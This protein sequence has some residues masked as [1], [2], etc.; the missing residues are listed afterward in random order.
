M[1]GVTYTAT[2][3]KVAGTWSVVVPGSGLIADSDKTI[4]AKVTFTDAAGNSSNITESKTYTVDTTAPSA[5]V[6]DPINATNP[7]T[8]TA[9]AGSTVKV[10]FPDGTTATVVAGPD[11]KWTVPNPGDLKDGDKVTVVATDPAGN[12]S[13]P[14]TGTVDAV[15][16]AVTVTTT[17]TNDSTP[18]LSGTINDPTAKVVV[19]VDGVN[20]SATNNGDGTWTLADNTL[21]VLTDGPHTVTVTATD[22]AGNVGTTNAV[23][24]VD[25]TAPNAPVIDPINATN[26]VTGTAEAGSTVKVTF[27]DGTTATVVAG[28]DGKW[29]V[30]NPGD[31]KDGDKVTVVATDPAGN[32]SAPSTGTVDAVAPA[33]TVTTT[34][35][36]DSTPALS[37]TINDPTAKVVVTVDGVNYPA[38]N[39][40]DGTWTLADNTLPVLTDG[41]HTVTVTA[42]DPAGNVGTTNAV[43]TVDTAAPNAP[44]LDPINATNPVTGTAE[45]GSTV[46]VSFPD[47]TTATVVAGPDGKWTVPN[48]GDL[49]D[50]Q[51]VT[52]TATDPAGNPSLPGTGVVDAVA[53]TV[54]VT[55][56]LT[57]DSTPALTGT[58]NDPTAKVV[59]TVDGVAYPAVNN[60]DGTWTLADNTLP[61]LTD[62]PHTVTVTATDPA[63]NV[64]TGNAV[65]TVDTTAPSAPVLDPINATNPVTGTAE[66]GST[67][68]V[69][70]PDGTTAT[71]VAGPDG[72]WTVLNPGDLTDGQTVTATATDPAGNPSL[73]GTGVVDAVA[74]T[75]AV[76][77]AL[78]NDST[79]ALTGTVNDPTAKVVVTVDGVNYPATN[80]GDGTWTLADNTL[81]VLTDG[82]H[83]VTVT[84]TDPAGN[85]GTGNAVVTVDTTAPSAPILDPINATNPVTGTAEPGST[86]TVSFP[87][88]TTATVV[89]GPDGKWTVPNP[90]DLTDGQTVTAT[91]TD[92]AGNPSLPGT[93][94]VDAVA[95]TVAVTT[96]LTND[97]TPA[98][99]GTVND[100]TAKV[101]VTVDGV[102]YPA[103]NN[104][105]GTWTLADN[106]LPVLT[107]GPHTVTVTATD[108]AGNVG[109][110]NAVVTV[111]TTAPSA[112]VLDPINATNPVTGTAEPGSTV[113]VSFPDGTTATV[114]AGPDGKWTVPN[115]GDLTD[116]QTVTATA[117]DPAGN[118]SL[119]GTGVVDAV[120]PTVA[121]TTALTNDSTPALT[122]TVNDPTAKVVVTVD[123]VAY[124]AVNNGD[125]TWTL[126]DNTLP[127]LTDGPHT[128]TVTATDPAGNVGTGN[129]VVTVDTTAPSAPVLDPI[130]AT[131]PV[132]GTAEPGST[133]TVSFPDGTTATVVAGPDGK[134]TVP[135]PGDLTDGQTV[136]ATATD[137]AGNP[138]LPGTGVVDAVAPTVAV[139]TAL[140]N[141]STP[142]L[143]GTVNDPTAKVVVTVDGVNYP[144]T[145]NGDGTWTLADNTL[146]VLA[147]GPHTVTVTA[148]DPAGNVG[149]TNA[150]V[151]VDTTAPTV[152]LSDVT[153]NDST[154]ELT[155]T[156]NDPSATVVVTVNGVNYTAVNN[157]NGSWTLA[158]NTL[159]VL[160]DGP[161]TVT[162]T[163]TDPAGNV[164][165]TSAVVTVDT[166]AANLLGP[167]TVPDDLNADGFINASELGTDGSF[168]AR[169]ALGPDAA[170]GTVVNVNGTDYTVSATD[171]SNG[172]ITASIPVTA[173]GPI[174]IHAQAVDSQGHISSPTNV[175]VT[176]D[177]AAPGTPVLDPI[178]A[179]NPVTGTAEPGSTV[180]VSFPDGTTATVVAGPDGKWTV[181]N[182]GDLTDGQT[183][184]AT[185]IDPAGN[186]S[187]PGTGVVDAVAPT[188]AVTTTLTNDSTPAL[189]GTVNDPTAKVVVTV[190]GVNYPATNNGDG[191]WTLAD[192]TLPVLTD[193]PHTVTVTA[194]DPAG[195]VG[196]GNAVVT[197]DTTAPSAPVLDPINAT[198]PVTG[199]A[200]PG[201]TVTVSFPDGTTAT[202]VAGPDGKWTVPNPGDLTDGQTVTAT[203][204]DPAGNPS[205]PGT[206]VVDAVAPTVAVTTALTNDS[207]PALTGTVND[208]TAKVVVTVDG[209][210]Y[211]AVNNGDGTWT[212]ADNTLPVLTD[213]PHTVTVTATDPAGNVGTGNAVVTVDT[214]APS[215]PVLD[216]INATNPVTGTAE[217]GSTV[218]VSFP[219]GTTATVVAGPDGKWTVPNP[220]D[221]TDGQT[222]T[223]TATDPA[224]NPSLP[225]TGVVDAVAPTVAV[226]TALTND[227]T[228]AL[229]GTVNDPTAKVVVTVDGVNYPAT[230]NGD[231]TWTLADNT[232]PVLADGPHTVTVTATDP[233]GNVGTTNAVVTVDTTAPTVGLSDVT[234]NDS[235]PEL[236][237]TVNDPSATVVVTVNGVNYTAVNNGNGSWT[238][239]DN[240][241]PVLADGPHT[242]TVTA[243]DPAG[244]VSTTS[245]V[246]T[247]DTAAANLLGP[248]TVPDDLNADGFINASELGTDGSFN[249]R[250]ALG[251]DA[252]VGTVVN[253]NG[254]DYTVSA[255]DLSN[256]YITA[257]IPVTADGPI[258]I[259]AQAVDSQGHISSPADV[260]VTVDTAAPSAPVLDPI[261]AT[262]PVTGTAEPGS[263]V[264]VSFP[265]GTTATVVA[266]PDGKWTVPNPGDLTDGQTVTAIATDPAGNPSLPGTGTVDALAPT[267]AL[268]DVLTND[269]TPALTGTVNDPTAKVVV[270]VDGVNYPATN[271]GDGTWTLADNTLPVLTDGPHTVTVTAT[272]P[273]GNV[274]TG[275]AVVTVDTTA[276]TVGLSDV[277]TNDSTPE[278]T[279]T[280]NDPT[281]TVVVTVNGV[282]YTAVN[283][284]N[285]SWTLADNTLP[286]LADGPHTVTVTATDPAGNVS[287]TSAVVTVDTAAAN[288]L[289]P[290]T[291]PDD[292]NA[293]GFI[294]TSELGTDGSFDARVALG[295]DAAVGT[296]VNV[297]GTDYTVSATDLSNGYIT[298]SI[299]VTADG[300]ITIHAQ[301]VDSQG[302][303]SSPADVIVT[304]DT[305]AP[306]APVL[307]PINAT[308]PVTGTAEP[309]ST[310]T[311]SFPDGT[312]ATVVAGPDGKW[313]VPNPGDLTD[314]QT[315]TAIATD[316]AGNPSLPGTGTVDALAPTVALS[317]VLTN[318]STPAL[319]G[320]VNDPTAKVVVTVDGVDYPATNNGDGTWTLADNTLPVL[321]DGPHTVTVTATDPAGNV[322]TGNAVVT[323]DTTAPTVGLSDVTTNDSTPE[324]TGTVNDPTATVVV[325]VNGVNYTAVNNGNGSWTLADNTLPVLAD[326][327]HT[328]TVTAT[329]PA[330]NVSTTSAV[331]TV[332]TAAANLLGPITVPDDLNADGFINTSE[333][334]TDGS[335]DARVAL[336]PDAAVGTVVNV[337][338][339]D[340]T[341]SATDL[342]NGYITASIPVTADGPITIH[343]QAVDSQGH[344]S[345]PADVIVTVDTAAPSA[346]VL[347]PINATNPVTGTAEPGS[348]VTVS[349]PDGTTATVVAGPDGKWTVPNPGDLTDGQTVTAIATDPAGNPSLPGTGT[350]D[351]LAPT[352]ALSDV[353]TNDSTPA[354]TGTVNDPTAKVVVTVDGVNYPATNN[355]DGT[356]TLADNTLP[357]LTDGPHTVTVTAT[358]PA[359]N[360]G[361]GNAV[362]T[363]DTTAPTVGLSDVTTNDSTPELTGTVN[364]PSA[365]VVVTVNGVNYTAV[366]NGNG[367]WT[368][369][370]NTLPVLADGPHTVTVTATDPAGNVS[371]TS[372]VV[373]VDTA[374]ANLLG[375]ITVP[376]DL[377]A[378]GFINTSELGTDGS[379]DARVA[380]GPDAAVGTVVNVNGT[381]YTVSATDLSNGYITA[382]IPVT[383]DG[384]ITIHAQAVDSQGHISSP[385]DVIVTVDT[386]APS[387][388][389]LDPINATNPVTGT[390]EPGSTVTVSFP[391]GTTATVVAGP[392]GKWTAPNP[393][394]LTD[395]QTVTAIATDPAG[396][397]SL[398]GTGTVDAL[399]PT[400]ALSDVLTN[401]STPALTGTVNDPTAKVVVTVDGVN[402]PATNNGD[403][404][405]TLADNTLPVLTDGPHTV[406]VTAT[407]PA[408]NV[409]TTNAV[410][411]VDTTAPTVGLSDVTTNDSTPELTGTVNDPTATVVVTVNGVNYT[412]VNNGNGSWTLA[413]NTLPVLADGPHT[414][415]VTA[416]D[417]AGNVST[418]SAVV[419][420]DTAAANL[421]GP[422][423][424]PDDLNADGF[425][426]TSELGT[427]GSFDARVALG[428]D[429]AV[430]TVVNV[431]GTDYTVSATDLSNGYITASIPV[432]ADGPITIHA[433]AV[434]SQGHISSPAD[435]IVTVDTAAPSAPVLDPINATNP[436]TGTAEPGSTV[437][438]SFPDGTTA[439]VVAGPDGK[440]TAPNPGDLTD[441]QTVTAIATDPAGNPSLPGT[442]TVDALAPTVALS[443]VLTNDSTPAL[444]GTVN[445]PTAKVVVTVDGVN[446]PATNNGDG[447]WTLADNTLPVLTDGPH[448]VTVT[449]TDPAGN[450]GT[451]NAVVTV[452]TTAPTV[453]LSDVTTNDSTPELTGTV[454]DPTAT[455]VVTV[456]G[457]NY[458]AVNNGNGSW[459]LAD[460]TLP[461]LADGPHTVTVTATDP[462]GNVSIPATGTVTISSSSILAFDNTD[463]AVLS[464]QPSL[465]GNDVSLGSTSYLVLTSVAG[466][467][468]QLGGNSLGFTVAAGHEGEVTFQ[469]SGLIDAAVLSDY[470][471][472]VQKFN[473][474]TNQ[475]ESIHGDANSSLISLHL[476]GIGTGNVPGAVLDGLD[477]GQYRAFLAYDG[478]LGLGV[479]GSLSAT[480]DDYDLSVAGGYQVG[481]AEGN[482][483]TDPDPTTG[484]VDQVTATTYVSSVNGH[485]IDANG[486]TFA[487]TYGTITFYQDGSYVYVPNADGSGIG[488]TDVFTYTLTDSATGATGQANLNIVFDS[489]RAADNLVEVELNPQYQLVGT[490]TDSAFYGVLLN[491]GNIVDLQLLTVDTVDFTIAAG[492]EG[493]ATFNFNSLIGASALGNYN[494][495]LQ[496]YN[497]VTGQW[498]AVNG[499][500]DRSLLNLTLL[501][502]T[503]TAQI[504]GLTEGEY[505]AFL[506]FNGLVGGAVAV[507]L[508]GSVDVYNPAVITGYNV[509][510]AHGNLISDPNTNGAVDIATPNSIISEV[511]GVT[512][513]ASPTEIIG[514]HGTLLIYANGDYTYT[515]NAD[516]AGLGQ[517]DQFTYTLLDPASNTT[518]QATFYVHLD[519]KVVDMN[520]NAADPSQPATVTITAV[521][522]AVNAAIAAEPHLIEDDRALGSATYLALLSLAGINLQ[523]PLPF[524]NSTVNFNVG[525][526]ETGTATFKYSSLINEGA[527]GDYQ[528]VVQKFNTAT[529]R[530]ESITGS[531]EASLLNLSVLGIGVNATPGV[532]VEGLDEGQY[533]AFMTYNGLYGKSILGT[534]SGTMD[535]YDPNQIDFTGL[536]SEGNVITGLGVGTHA[537][538]VTGFTIVDSVT[539]NGVTTNIDPNTGTIIQGQYGTLQIFA[540]GDYIYTPNNT[541][542][543]LGLVD[544]FTYTLSDPLGGNISASLD[545]TIGNNTP[546]IAVDDLAVA[547]INPEYLQIGNDVAVGSTTYLALLSLTDNFDFQAGGQSVNFTL[548]N[549]T[550]N[551]VTFNYSA[552]ISASLLADYVLVV[553]K[554]DTATNQWVAVNGTGDANLLSLAAFGGNSVT[555]EGLAAGQYR[556]YMTYAGSGVGVSLLGTLS[557]QKDVFDATNITGYSTKVA[558]GNVIHDV[559]LNGHADTASGFSTVTSVEFNGIAHAV[560]P[561]GVTNIVGDHGTLS[562]YANGNYSYQPNGEAA[563]L[564]Q[565]DQ[566][567]YTLSDGL[568]TSQAT[569]YLHI[570]SD[571]VDM[572]W[573]TSDPSQPAD[574]TITPVDAIDN[575][576]SAAVD[577]VPQGDLGVAVGSATYL[578]LIGITEN[579]NVPVLG[580]PS[581][582]FTI[583]AGHEA[584]VTFSYSAALSV[585][586]LNDY[587]VVLQQ[588]GSDGSWYNINGGTSTGLL[589]IGLLGSGGIGVTVPDLGQGEYRAFMVYT[590]LGVGI[591]GTMSVVKDDFNYTV[592]PTN[593]AIV[594]DGNVLTNDITTLTTQVSTVTSEVVGALPQTVGTDTV[595]N[596]AYGTLVISTNGHYTYTP[597]TIDTSAIGKVDSFTYTIRDALT[598]ATDTA[599]LHVQVGSP[600]VNITWDSANP[601]ADGVIP[602][603]V[604]NADT[605]HATISMKQ[606]TDAVA[607]VPSGT[608]TIGNLTGFPP[609]PVLSNTVTS[610]QFVIANNTVSDVHVELDYTATLS[611]SAL[612]TTGYKIQQLVGGT[613]VDTVY[614]GSA[615]ALA[616][617]LGAPAYSADVSHLSAGTYRVVFSLS[618]LISLGTVTLD[619]AVTTKATHLDQ[620][621][622]DGQS[623]W[624]HGNILLGDTTGGVA[625]TSTGSQLYVEVTPGNYQIAAGQA[626]NTGEGTL[627]LYHDGSYHYKALDTAANATIDTIN[628][629]LVSVTGAES[630]STLTIN[631]SQELN[632]LAVSTG[633]NDTFTLGNGSDTLIYNT[634][635]AAS[636]NSPTGGN[637]TAGGVD[638][639]TDFHVG[640]TATDNQADKIDISNLL[641]THPNSLTIGQ[642]VSVSYNAATQNAT[643]SVDRDGLGTTYTSTQ[644]LTIH[645]DEPRTSLTLNDLLNNGQIIY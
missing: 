229:T 58:V 477:A 610:N 568:N 224:G 457:V 17:L 300:P 324:L 103:T 560:N 197:V 126:A 283:N 472:V 578:A 500:G 601:G 492:Q 516:S 34:L 191:T 569:L 503:P 47:G 196:T 111:D 441:G 577:I 644:L 220:G 62:G 8:G 602:L 480:M 371:T 185:A 279:G 470:K 628:Y 408:G 506:S 50:G 405:W 135:N 204:T 541:N 128:V 382:S 270:T 272:D 7:V 620:Y 189:S 583:D 384:P 406:T 138:S 434:D 525:A 511:N 475:W 397:P 544:H 12:P 100:P 623:D 37:G 208:P 179:T 275:N 376:D 162:V 231:G 82:P 625:D 85:V 3:D 566:F 418:T 284:G 86:V 615:T 425:I 293:D 448:T 18:A 582:G 504:G 553:Q 549:A 368:L 9:E 524:V 131:N 306:S 489:I 199:T 83:T 326:G 599:T 353:L 567:T 543:N 96:T 74:P 102:N 76:T 310:V 253:V 428:P 209:V 271:N 643:I 429:A 64:G 273:A 193:G 370:D 29:T 612:P 559:G 112:P 532:V 596:G 274:G 60:G 527:L 461:V 107:D 280:V 564:G 16:P 393:G 216:P 24:T 466:L 380:L 109:T 367:S 28:P 215:A 292:L 307:D 442:G 411:T 632:S 571:A 486:E 152:G 263:T 202:V 546:V 597:N 518:S 536:A 312:T 30:P 44:V 574:I 313:T 352:V 244:N 268:S 396:N 390:A 548:T 252:A 25:T 346:P 183:V 127:V 450:V 575:V 340:Y 490:E 538:V 194:T 78:T 386:A 164:S 177:T 515:P 534:L 337:N 360:V 149:T 319:T 323:V 104:G 424:V 213:G 627:Y 354:L 243:T 165:T 458:T 348:T 420:V 494:V 465:V 19:T 609:L 347:D 563:S 188:V 495:V 233:A 168:N 61:V 299:P 594:A 43:V 285:G 311:V 75:V 32:P 639:W 334:G 383:A 488:Q 342:S 297:N 303:I 570:D 214:T 517:V 423:T 449:A 432:T 261:N 262:N 39:N 366:N 630:T 590:G 497:D 242:V 454:N 320:T 482:V 129:A 190:D 554:F 580:T 561:T 350:V 87:D 427:D 157:G 195:N 206:G 45:A 369:A 92:P 433:Q 276:P 349:F 281:A 22:P 223:A 89:A 603:P 456:N 122:G 219:D 68:T 265:D 402:Y 130:N 181:P 192:N 159:P 587:K 63:G 333:L 137:P 410:V 608:V 245:A 521:D 491:V 528:L 501:G 545:F 124:P 94:V 119:P 595:I 531:S 318:D 27:P 508:N 207:T 69:S 46:T 151:T 430:G 431:N 132:T 198:N 95:P 222:V 440:W 66:P 483:I 484:Q 57:N 49:T 447:T 363:V 266:G 6:I 633:A 592:A 90:G 205:L 388:P 606:V 158:D 455:V 510:A 530:W 365:T 54:A 542:A 479:L 91:A 264:T 593:N 79:P 180:T 81:P 186:P 5:P 624:I 634:L 241:L 167:I 51:T 572:T 579:L 2:V 41:P 211:P 14:S 80:N 498:E 341:V 372:A 67:V 330:G 464:P 444:T 72:K 459:T 221:L 642:Y 637:T 288:L 295:P 471:L 175:I 460:N 336:G 443:D 106:T 308:N 143:T 436:V 134:W 4:D 617:V 550:L 556:A 614:S 613:W 622:P 358:D 234:T 169:V 379:F 88:G 114:V 551:D 33:V 133:V 344:I 227:S 31:L 77:T 144:A 373:T 217:P 585:S 496:K 141:D 439:T 407:D 416:T 256:G 417:P 469:Y 421:L 155:G 600:D 35:T 539:V 327:P 573:N 509:V 535:V 154:P 619:S 257:S 640:N 228:P 170:V 282:N 332:D 302:H 638:T 99:S 315:V 419:T 173:D 304:V 117:T 258:T 15:A 226:T 146:P 287:T 338:G 153:T 147:D 339:T 345:S 163:A 113:T 463:H 435:V 451:G 145:N 473:T 645:I 381:D 115:P 616:G 38:T 364:D 389:V 557:V 53:P 437:T 641:L 589:N 523:A 474:T 562:I 120:A 322:G 116:G 210:A 121:V 42:T 540:N 201:S 533:R 239:A 65:V 445:D 478:L 520:W 108:P 235:T 394:D 1:N 23:V 356:W 316:P 142:A 118:P 187:V 56:A 598:G 636:V 422:I 415:T 591:L 255:T 401:D 355:G 529:N 526:G 250:V 140:T 351:A 230:N 174:T 584:E 166:A 581:V 398:P 11:G 359:G 331:V 387:A 254:T 249:A 182:P 212:L 105:D 225:G 607:D 392:D 409:G 629:K 481:N 232:L 290:I 328:V 110:G 519:S 485:P 160:A 604:A 156:V 218:T 552:L 148:T 618:S 40:G 505:R 238:L 412:A 558:E 385:A 289:G 565:V 378:D 161:H 84:A 203:A 176:V 21:P 317:D 395:G 413:D 357:V 98:L 493:V 635:T 277:T 278:L 361:T 576:A 13:A 605:N 101:V 139:T 476:L 200:E 621:T 537:D 513:G 611:L 507:T 301:A 267:V 178:N 631:L 294:N 374:A 414:V 246:V 586:L 269:S 547:V 286:V 626:I 184:T 10:T 26:P 514:T 59:V 71:V 172:Y 400:V 171:L 36:N 452:D 123:G 588:K 136:T 260:I 325:T 512:V 426:N 150:V 240:T 309:G 329:D 73:P 236:T 247:V 48:P 375:P 403:G 97:S 259:H 391:D 335:F 248:I 522:D 125:G 453:G 467:D 52:A 468:L 296:V 404:T 70:F 462:A 55:T 502:N 555:L 487:G 499:T 93:G 305:A 251:P 399:A 362:V 343:A 321:T 291:V 377:N 438:V 20:Y 298:A 314:G 446:Y 237:G